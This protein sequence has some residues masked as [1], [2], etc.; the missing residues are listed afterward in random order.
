LGLA[1]WSF[2]DCGFGHQTPEGALDESPESFGRFEEV[3]WRFQE[4]L[5]RLQ[6]ASELQIQGK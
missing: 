2:K 5:G 3:L 6:E 1:A 4:A